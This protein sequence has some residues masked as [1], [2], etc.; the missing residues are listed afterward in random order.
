MELEHVSSESSK[1]GTEAGTSSLE[2]L[3]KEREKILQSED[4]LHGKVVPK[5]GMI[6]NSEEEVYNMYIEFA[7]QEGFGITKRSTRSGEDGKFKYYTLSCVRGGKRISTAKNDFNPRPSTKTN[8]QAKINV[9]IG[10]DGCCT[11]S[12]VNL[13]H[14][15]ALSPHKSRFQKCNKKMDGYVKRRLE[16]NDQAGIGLSKN[17]H[18]LA[19]ESGGYENLTYTEKDCRN[20]IVKARQLRLGFG[21]AQA[22]GNYFSRMHQRNSNFFLYD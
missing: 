7:R 20:Y 13:E 17:F 22:L 10:N 4:S 5:A 19:I 14:N 18:S 3:N 12:R 11:I 9:I 21:D 8:C 2:T 15:H 1:N 16:L 6:L